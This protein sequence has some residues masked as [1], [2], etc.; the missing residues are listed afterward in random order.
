MRAGCVSAGA[1]ITLERSF[2]TFAKFPALLVL[3]PAH[4][5]LERGEHVSL[6]CPNGSGKTTLIETLAGLATV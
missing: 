6:V 5:W 4:L 2:A 1:G 3:E